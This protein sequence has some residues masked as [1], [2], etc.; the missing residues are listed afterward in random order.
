MPL[1]R[2]PSS[3]RQQCL[4][5][6]H[7]SQY[8]HGMLVLQ[9][10]I[11]ETID[12]RIFRVLKEL[13]EAEYPGPV[14]WSLSRFGSRVYGAGLPSSDVD[15]VCEL[16]RTP[17]GHVS[18]GPFLK[19]F[20]YAA[21]AND[22]FTAVQD[23]IDGKYT[24]RFKHL[25]QLVDFT[26]HEGD[27]ATGHTPTILSM[28]MKQAFEQRPFVFRRLM[29]LV[30]DTAK[31]YK[32]CYNGKGP[33]GRQLKAVHVALLGLAWWEYEGN[34]ASRN[35]DPM[36][37]LLRM[38]LHW[39]QDFDFP[40]HVISPLS[41]QPFQRREADPNVP[42]FLK[43]PADADWNL[44]KLD[45]VTWVETCKCAQLAL[46]EL[47]SL[48][49]CFWQ[50]AYLHMDHIAERIAAPA[51]H[52]AFGCS[53]ERVFRGGAPCPYPVCF[54]S[55][56][57]L[58]AQLRI[59]KQA[60]HVQVVCCYEK[61]WL[62][63][64]LSV[65]L[66]MILQV[67]LIADDLE[68]FFCCHD[69]ECGWVPRDVLILVKVVDQWRGQRKVVFEPEPSWSSHPCFD[70]LLTLNVGDVVRMKARF[71]NNWDGWADGEVW[72]TQGTREG[73]FPL[74]AV[75]DPMVIM[76]MVSHQGVLEAEDGASALV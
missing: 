21:K 37:S 19:K 29:A 11:L 47:S 48:S 42:V 32:F 1:V 27:V 69:A 9:D 72:G 63:H 71:D 34:R 4:L 10:P 26:A 58:Q 17:A 20:F 38:F 22:E 31:R 75:G 28:A 39:I 74:E 62:E 68:F 16:L 53:S 44:S 54:A 45:D 40:Q 43:A 41:E 3:E 18:V 52:V 13:E 2:G 7:Y 57:H 36:S 56:A 8:L 70:R 15:I 67:I 59:G 76:V 65:T 30:V 49:M 46:S 33:I 5:C 73:V 14:V 35:D 24:V 64:E 66:G 6:E 55:V 60:V 50:D 23:M 61:R 12:T 25:G 51:G